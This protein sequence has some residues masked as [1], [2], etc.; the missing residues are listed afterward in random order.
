MTT[1]IWTKDP[2]DSTWFQ[3]IWANFLPAGETITTATVTSSPSITILSSNVAG[4]TVVNV[5]VSGGSTNATLS[6]SIQTSQGNTFTSH[7]TIHVTE[8]VV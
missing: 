2:A 8:R 4:G 5:N 7:K 1:P 3:F 6:C